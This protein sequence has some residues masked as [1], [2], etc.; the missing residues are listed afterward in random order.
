MSPA[1]FLPIALVL[2]VVSAAALYWGQRSPGDPQGALGPGGTEALGL[3]PEV[4]QASLGGEPIETGQAAPEKDPILRETIESRALAEQ[5]QADAIEVLPDAK[6]YRGVVIDPYGA[7]VVGAKLKLGSSKIE[8]RFRLKATLSNKKPFVYVDTQRDGTF[9]VPISEPYGLDISF[10][11]EQRG[12]QRLQGKRTLEGLHVSDLGTFVLEFGTVVYG[13]VI[14]ETGGPVRDAEVYRVARGLSQEEATKAVMADMGILTRE[15]AVKTDAD[16][17]FELPYEEPGAITLV[18]EHESYLPTSVSA[19]SPE[20]GAPMPEWTIQLTTGGVIQ[21]KLLGYPKGRTGVRI[22]AKQIEGE[23]IA[24]PEGTQGGFS[25]IIKAALNPAGDFAEDVQADGSFLLK[26]LPPQGR[27]ELRAYEPE[28]F[29]EQR[30][31]TPMVVAQ[32]GESSVVLPFDQGARVN[33]VVLDAQTKAPVED[34]QVRAT[35][36]EGNAQRLFLAPGSDRRVE[37]HPKGQVSMYEVRPPGKAS[38]LTIRIQAPGYFDGWRTGLSVSEG[39]TVQAGTILLDP[40]PTRTFLVLDAKTREPIRRAQVSLVGH[41]KGLI[42]AMDDEEGDD[43]PQ[44]EDS[45]QNQKRST[46]RTDRDGRCE[47]SLFRA[48]EATLKVNARGYAPFQRSPFDLVSDA[49]DFTVLLTRGS[50]IEFAVVDEDGV[51]VPNAVLRGKDGQPFGT[52]RTDSNGRKRRTRIPAGDYAFRAIRTDQRNGVNWWEAKP[53][54]DDEWIPL[55][56]QSGEVYELTLVVPS[57]GQLRGQVVTSTGPLSG[58]TVS[59]SFVSVD[60][61]GDEIAEV[62]SNFGQRGQG[63]ETDGKGQFLIRGVGLGY[64]RI[65]VRHPDFAMPHQE[66]VLVAD[67]D[68]KVLI[69]MPQ[70]AVSG[71]ITD[72]N[73]KPIVGAKVFGERAP[74][75]GETNRQRRGFFRAA[76]MFQNQAPH[77]STDNEGEYVLRGLNP[78]SKLRVRVEADGFVTGSSE[79]FDLATNQLRTATNLRLE[80]AG[81]IDVTV[82]SE[83]PLSGLLIVEAK[84]VGEAERAPEESMSILKGGVGTLT[85][86][87]AG[88]WEVSL[89]QQ[90]MNRS[91]ARTQIEPKRVEVQTGKASQVRFE[92][93]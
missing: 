51:A 48:E 56:V 70:T 93:N 40:A 6:F 9:E 14:D 78:G 68:Q 44:V 34:F 29:V 49:T 45:A 13:R 64:Y 18:V 86:L 39:A 92:L 3:A 81:S 59:A 1:R 53:G 88:T 80:A 50:T 75:E 73:G 74:K 84:F 35:W 67:A 33:F 60:D 17:R 11:V 42:L 31:L 55:T 32:S 87:T 38:E 37:R 61:P 27:F 41:S 71:R 89:T 52:M 76:R 16:G 25:E 82:V 36:P 2:V 10:L 20:S 4:A 5:R 63:T 79:P 62:T 22:A 43:A 8:D 69:Q 24:S 83:E 19:T 15:G 28:N 46:N 26:G 54:D 85:G 57:V 72:S 23:R 91:G 30:F 58:A 12:Y 7:P 47:V 90:A 65:F 66:T 77:A 21:G